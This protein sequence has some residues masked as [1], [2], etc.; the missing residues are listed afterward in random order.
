MTNKYIELYD[1]IFINDNDY[2]ESLEISK[3]NF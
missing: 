3:Y 2:R 1:T